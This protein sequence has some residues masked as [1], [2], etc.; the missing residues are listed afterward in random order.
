MPG[1]LKIGLDMQLDVLKFDHKWIIMQ[2]ND[3]QSISLED[4][5]NEGHA[6]IGHP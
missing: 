2:H 3:Q 6:E 1:N 5:H 4:Q